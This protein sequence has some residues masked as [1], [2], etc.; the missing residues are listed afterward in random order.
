[1]NKCQGN[2]ATG[3]LCGRTT[4]ICVYKAIMWV[5]KK[6]KSMVR[7]REIANAHVNALLVR[8]LS[9]GQTRLTCFSQTGSRLCNILD[10]L[11]SY[12]KR[13]NKLHNLNIMR[14]NVNNRTIKVGNKRYAIFKC[15]L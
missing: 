1:M 6:K 15:N 10:K 7:K 14:C 2:K 8:F 12:K 9:M 3:F 4:V 11:I 13:K 5:T